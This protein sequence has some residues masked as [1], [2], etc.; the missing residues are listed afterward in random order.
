[1]A[2]KKIKIYKRFRVVS[3]NAFRLGK[4]ASKKFKQMFYPSIKA[5]SFHLEALTLFRLHEDI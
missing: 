3:R 1:M 5:T 2:I 4:R